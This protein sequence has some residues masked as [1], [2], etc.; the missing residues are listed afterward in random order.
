MLQRIGIILLK[1]ILLL[2]HRDAFALSPLP[3]ALGMK[4]GDHLVP[5]KDG[6]ICPDFKPPKIFACTGSG[7]K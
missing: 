3:S 1:C 7:G 6:Q 2:F 5:M 4:L